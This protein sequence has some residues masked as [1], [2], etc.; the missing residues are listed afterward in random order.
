ML[1]VWTYQGVKMDVYGE[2]ELADVFADNEVL[3]CDMPASH[4][5]NGTA[6]HSHNFHPCVFCDVDIVK[7]NTPEGYNNCKWTFTHTIPIDLVRSMDQ[8]RRLS[9][10]SSELLL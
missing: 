7:I 6:G 10:A 9:Y 1:T 5:C 2:E 3:A 8:Q 4:K